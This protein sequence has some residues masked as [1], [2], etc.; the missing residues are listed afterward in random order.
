MDLRTQNAV[1]Q[2]DV[3]AT[4]GHERYCAVKIF[5]GGGPYTEIVIYYDNISVVCD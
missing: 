1:Q 4:A 5:H 3:R 2:K